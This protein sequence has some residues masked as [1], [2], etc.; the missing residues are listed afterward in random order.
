M[1]AALLAGISWFLGSV[2][3][4]AAFGLGFWLVRKVTE[5]LDNWLI[6]RSE[7]KVAR[8]AQPVPV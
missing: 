3:L 1:V 8:S 4:G 6:T 5:P 7:L 2:T